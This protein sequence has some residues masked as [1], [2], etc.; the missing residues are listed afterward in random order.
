[1]TTNL[2]EYMNYVLKGVHSVP[3]STLAKTT[4]EKTK[5]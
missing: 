5:L 2:V 3:I 1:M 4:F